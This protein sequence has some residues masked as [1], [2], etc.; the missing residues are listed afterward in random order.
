MA[1]FYFRLRFHLPKH[2]SI[3]CENQNLE[4][5]THD[6]EPPIRLRGHDGDGTIKSARR[7]ILSGGPYSSEH[8]ASAAGIRARN[9]LML[10]SIR[11]HVGIDLG[12]NH[13]TGGMSNHL[14]KVLES[15]SGAQFFDD[16]HGLFIYDGMEE[17]RFVHVGDAT[18]IAGHS[19]G[20]FVEQ[21][22]QAH[23]SEF[24]PTPKQEV[25]FELF[26]AAQFEL[27]LRSR[28]LTL[29]MSIESLLDPIDRERPVQDHVR[30][31]IERTEQS[32]LSTNERESLVGSLRWLLKDSIGRTG[33]KLA[34]RLL[35]GNTYGGTIPGRF[36]R[37]CYDL[38]SQLVHRGE[39]ADD[40]GTVA[41]ELERFVADLLNASIQPI[42][43]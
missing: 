16:V 22:Q 25:A 21:F 15:Q 24:A 29:V 4:I 13:S 40:L 41:G 35:G 12:K 2:H 32:E 10:Y 19:M 33:T 37:H 20:A 6:D 34:T 38:R 18:L 43:K 28:F 11:S 30:T 5:P 1:S 17:T 31:L 14:K 36:F 39:S 7:L 3:N 27:S 23:S 26:G 42:A 9:A 8:E